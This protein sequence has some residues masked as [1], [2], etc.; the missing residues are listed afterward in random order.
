[1]AR[2]QT[3][4]SSNYQNV[5]S[6][7]APAAF[8]ANSSNYQINGSVEMMT[9]DAQST[10]YRTQSGVPLVEGEENPSP[11][12]G[13]QSGGSS[14]NGGGGLSQGAPPAD[15][16]FTYKNPTFLSHQLI[17]GRRDS[18]WTHIVVNG[19]ENGVILYP[20]LTWER[21]IPLF[22]GV[23]ALVVQAQ[24]AS[25]VRSRAVGGE[26]SRLLIGDVNS[27]KIVDDADLSLFARAWK[28]YTFFADFNEDSKVDDADLSLLVAYWGMTKPSL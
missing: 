12:G 26:I 28:K 2:A 25:G 14:G 3:Q 1:M 22:L 11:S 18:Q 21:D 16:I 13:S 5:G 23:N 19:S 4:T 9:G 6:T 8:D 24:S 20:D 7:F 15:P 10:N 27:D 17:Q